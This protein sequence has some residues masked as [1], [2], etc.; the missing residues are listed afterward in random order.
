MALGRLERMFRI[1]TVCTGNICRSPMA[2]L[3]LARAF[4]EAQL[5]DSVAVD[6]AGTTDYEVGR[7]IDTR[8]SRKLETQGIASSEHRARQFEDR[9]FRERDLIL[10]LNYDHYQDLRAL[11]PDEQ[12]KAKV[13]M[14]RGFDP[15]AAGLD[16][17]DQGIEDPWYGGQSGF[18]DSWN[19]IEAAVPGIV[20]HVQQAVDA[21]R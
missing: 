10:A 14:L 7:P 2:E 4:E 5:S 6:S 18:D 1:I 20:R 3:M 12:G 17:S 13:Q 11:A 8:A 16:P 21:R 19:L 9:W 15:D